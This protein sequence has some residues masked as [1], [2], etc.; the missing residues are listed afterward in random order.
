MSQRVTDHVMR[1]PR[2]NSRM[3]TVRRSGINI[4]E[5][6]GCAGVFLDWG[7]LE[8]LMSIMDGQ[9]AEQFG[10]FYPEPEG[11]HQRVYRK[12]RKR[13]GFWRSIFGGG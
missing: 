4:D 13:G 5:C 12:D 7:E 6:T 10:S 9:Y 3:M 11:Q 8:H 1:C 2:C